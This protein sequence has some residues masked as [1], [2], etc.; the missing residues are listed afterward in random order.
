M[1]SFTDKTGAAW[2]IELTVG[3]ARK[4]KSRL[5]IDIEN[6]VTFDTK[7]NPQDASALEKIAKDSILLFD[8]IFILCENQCRERKITDEQFADLFNGD[9]IVKATDALLEEIINFSR[10]ARRK[11]LRKLNEISK[12]YSEKAGEK[13]EA[14]LQ[15]PDFRQQVESQ[16]ENVLTPSSINS[17]ESSV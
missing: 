17:Q 12:E 13:L 15:T 6:A 10:P 1:Q 5:G 11:V 7:E 8:I 3:T 4:I 9:T 16:I 2:D 14:I